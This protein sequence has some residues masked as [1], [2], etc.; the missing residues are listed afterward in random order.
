MTR[1]THL[2][3]PTVDK[4]APEKT[5]RK[6]QRL[7]KR[8]KALMESRAAFDRQLADVVGA[9]LADKAAVDPFSAGVKLRAARIG[10]LRDELRLRREIDGLLNQHEQDLRELERE[11][12]ADIDRTKLVIRERLIDVGYSGAD[13]H[14]VDP[15]KVQQ[16]WILAHPL[17][18]D[19]VT[20]YGELR[21]R[22]NDGRQATANQSALATVEN[23]LRD[24]QAAVL[25]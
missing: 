3:E 13:V 6:A 11:A 8:A 9:D 5:R 7:G 21:Q 17:V 1:W 25:A 12:F 16:G 24:I 19:A 4:D 15:A 22:A 14:D 10:L 2:V 20:R 23:Q 18:Q